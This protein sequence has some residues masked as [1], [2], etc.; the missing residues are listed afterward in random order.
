[1][2]QKPQLSVMS[3]EVP[4]VTKEEKIEMRLQALDWQKSRRIPVQLID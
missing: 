4:V 1:M 3:S 2:S